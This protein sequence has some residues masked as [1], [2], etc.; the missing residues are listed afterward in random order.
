MQYKHETGMILDLEAG[1]QSLAKF[2]GTVGSVDF[3]PETILKFH[4]Q[5]PGRV[6]ALAHTHPPQLYGLSARDRGMLKTWA[7]TLS[8]HP[9]RMVTVAHVAEDI[10]RVSLYL[11]VLETKE[12]WI[13]RGK[14]SP[15]EFTIELEEDYLVE[16]SKDQELLN[17]E[18]EI[19]DASYE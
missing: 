7:Y 19:I 10:F 9:L 2:D 3:D 1:M 14:N 8:P 6:Y 17:W 11:G 4:N 13:A 16:R 5:R 18:R 15:R 12:A